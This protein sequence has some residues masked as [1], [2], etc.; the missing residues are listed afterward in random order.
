[1]GSFGVVFG[2]LIFAFWPWHLPQTFP[3]KLK[4]VPEHGFD[5]Y[6]RKNYKTLEMRYLKV[7]HFP[8]GMYL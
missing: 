3:L 2:M 6:L 7:I 8:A 4:R 1:M 5:E